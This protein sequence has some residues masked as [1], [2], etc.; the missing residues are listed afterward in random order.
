MG[1]LLPKLKGKNTSDAAR[2]AMQLHFDYLAD[3]VSADGLLFGKNAMLA[4]IQF[5]YLLANLSNLGFLS[6]A[7]RLR[8]YWAA[9]QQQPGYKAAVAKAGNMAPTI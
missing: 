3:Q 9:L 5:S 8:A 7:P 6:D 4:D 1:L 2:T